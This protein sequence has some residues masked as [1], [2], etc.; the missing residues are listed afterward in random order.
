MYGE[1]REFN[2]IETFGDYGLLISGTS[3]LLY[4]VCSSCMCIHYLLHGSSIVKLALSLSSHSPILM[5]MMFWDFC[6]MCVEFGLNFGHHFLGHLV[7][8][9]IS[10]W[11][12]MHFRSLLP[13]LLIVY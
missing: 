5:N 1:S 3:Y 9:T 2:F 12:V 7:G 13:K 11:S 6:E 8:D 10:I 4:S